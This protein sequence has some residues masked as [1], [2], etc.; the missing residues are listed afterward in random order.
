MNKRFIPS[1]ISKERLKLVNRSIFTANM[2]KKYGV[3]QSY[4]YAGSSSDGNWFPHSKSRILVVSAETN[5]PRISV[6]LD[7]DSFRGN[8]GKA[9][10]HGFAMLKELRSKIG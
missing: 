4:D 5:K 1:A 9:V 6:S 10:Q 7:L 3:L 8:V 2:K